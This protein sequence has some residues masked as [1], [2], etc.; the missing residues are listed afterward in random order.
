MIGRSVIFVCI[1]VVFVA[2]ECKPL[3]REHKSLH[4]NGK[5]LIYLRKIQTD[6]VT[7]KSGFQIKSGVKMGI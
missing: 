1:A 6:V 5:N 4:K 2:I 7:I 3:H